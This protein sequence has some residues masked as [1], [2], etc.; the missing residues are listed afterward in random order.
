MA[1]K[2]TKNQAKTKIIKNVKDLESV[3]PLDKI[4]VTYSCGSNLFD[5]ESPSTSKGI[6][7][8]SFEVNNEKYFVISTMKPSAT[9]L[10]LY[11][12]N[13]SLYKIQDKAIINMV[14]AINGYC[15]KKKSNLEAA[16]KRQVKTLNASKLGEL[17]N[18]ENKQ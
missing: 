8:G 7:G 4:E 3:N 15:D 16:I 14:Q 17:S 6:Y 1:E 2:E 11:F 10:G 9:Y 13:S 12:L 5:L 18:Q